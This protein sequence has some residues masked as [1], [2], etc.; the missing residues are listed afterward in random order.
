MTEALTE[1]AMFIV[2][3]CLVVGLLCLAFEVLVT[4]GLGVPG[5]L[6]GILVFTA[7]GFAF[8]AKGTLGGLLTLAGASAVIYLGGRGVGLTVGHRIVLSTSLDDEPSPPEADM[9]GQEGVVISPLRP[10]GIARFGLKRLDVVS[11]AEFLP[12]GARVVVVDVEGN[13]IV[14]EPVPQA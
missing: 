11:R 10:A 4:P 9:S 13:R 7:I 8:W 1:G 2:F 12:R 5:V 6:G 3:G 14:V